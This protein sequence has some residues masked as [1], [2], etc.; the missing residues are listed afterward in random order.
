M[1][2]RIFII[3]I[4]L[5]AVTWSAVAQG[6]LKIGYTTPDYIL[7]LMPESKQIQAELESQSKQFQNMIDAKQK[8]LEILAADAQQNAASWDE[9]IRAEKEREYQSVLEGLQR[10]QQEAQQ[11]IQQKQQELLKPVYEKIGK[12]I[13]DV[14]KENGYTHVFNLGT[15]GIDVLLYGRQEDDVTNL[16]LK[17]LGITPPPAEQ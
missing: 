16:V 12:A 1:K 9:L 3:A 14:A 4:A 8:E 11:K 13:E 10:F 5:S 7:G 2:T 15:V 6:D 17:K